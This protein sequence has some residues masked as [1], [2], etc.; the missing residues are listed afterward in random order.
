MSL[1]L[2]LS[3]ALV[4]F[5]VLYGLRRVIRER[6][7]LRRVIVARQS[8]RKLC[9]SPLAFVSD[10]AALF[11][12]ELQMPRAVRLQP[13]LIDVRVFLDFYL[14]HG[15]QSML[16]RKCEDDRYMLNI[17]TEMAEQLL[18]LPS[19]VFGQEIDVEVSS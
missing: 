19:G 13:A 6:D 5:A 12:I 14:Q 3:S 2:H 7:F 4:F 11:K 17:R 18:Q 15:I 8:G 1:F 16:V 10:F 9:V